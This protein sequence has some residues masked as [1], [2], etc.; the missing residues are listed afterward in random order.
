MA[1][2]AGN[3]GHG[4]LPV[5]KRER[6]I[7][8][9]LEIV[10]E[11]TPGGVDT[12]RLRSTG[13]P[14]CRRRLRRAAITAKPVRILAIPTGEAGHAVPAVVVTQ[15]RGAAARP[16]R[17]ATGAVARG[18]ARGAVSPETPLLLLQVL[19]QKILLVFLQLVL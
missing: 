10:V 13:A 3:A 6:P 4:L 5:P 18:K 7:P 12:P 2:F 8:S 15:G 19:L 16:R 17:M 1:G 9:R 11:P 14:A